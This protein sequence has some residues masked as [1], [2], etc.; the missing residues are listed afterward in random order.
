MKVTKFVKLINNE[1]KSGAVLPAK[2][3]VCNGWMEDGCAGG[4]DYGCTGVDMGHCSRGGID[5]CDANGNDYNACFWGMT[6]NT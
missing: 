2:A 4:F 6:D 1:R 3:A 5:Y